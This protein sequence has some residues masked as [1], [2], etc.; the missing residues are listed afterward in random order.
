MLDE[1]GIS[2]S[3]AINVRRKMERGEA[4]VEHFKRPL[5]R[6]QL[7]TLLSKLEFDELY[8]HIDN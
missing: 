8:T 7:E 6:Q 5:I 3:V 1:K 4:T 2:I